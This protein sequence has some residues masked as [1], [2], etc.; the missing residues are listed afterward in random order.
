MAS[1]RYGITKVACYLGYITQAIAV[2]LMPLLYVTFQT[3][4]SVSLTEL[5]IMTTVLFV[6][7]ILVDL[8]AV[9]L[10]GKLSYR[11]GCVAAHIFAV[12]GLV[13]LCFLPSCFP[14]PYLGVITAAVF[15][16]IGGGLIEVLISPV[17]DA[18]PGDRKAGEMS[19]L[20]SFYCWGFVLVVLL[21]TLFFRVIGIAFWQWLIL[22]WA[23]IPAVTAI[24][25]AFVPIPERCEQENPHDAKAGRVPLTGIFFL[26]M[27][28]MLFA[29][30]TEMGPAQW[31]SLFA[32]EGL[33]V[34]KS[35]GDLLGPCAFAFFQGVSRITFAHFT[36]RWSAN[37]LL[38]LFGAI[39][40]VAY[41]VTALAP[42]PFLSLLG[43][44]LCGFGVGPMWPGVLSLASAR[45]PTGGTRLFAALAL[46]GD[47]G[48]SV[49]PAVIGSVSDAFHFG[50]LSMTDAL[51]G[52]IGVC[53]LFPALLFAALL[54]FGRKNGDHN[55]VEKS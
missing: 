48:C 53:T 21:S 23:V 55:L 16:A 47:L 52:G 38:A 24:L 20:H 13:G 4:F 3:Q 9:R 29:G 1:K 22:L 51:K 37:R 28:L 11:V 46:M 34:D 54:W 5:G 49:A 25:F 40:I 33:G 31:A 8:L 18:I 35:V 50:G 26:F 43:F 27:A 15:I 45:F 39:C 32:E 44:C 7:Q 14:D 2:N 41:L 6:T 19:L 10:G 42:W 30:A 17:I 12:T 36:R